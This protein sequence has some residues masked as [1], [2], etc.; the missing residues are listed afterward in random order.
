MAPLHTNSS[1]L[2][3]ILLFLVLLNGGVLY[4]VHYPTPDTLTVTFLDV[5]QGDAILIKAPTG[6]EVLVDGGRG[7]AVLNELPWAIGIFD[8]SL[9]MVIETHPDADHIGGLPEVFDRYRVEVFLQPG[10]VHDTNTVKL[11]EARADAEK[12]L[13]RHI[14]RR[15]ER[16]WL[17]GGAYADVLYPGEGIE[18]VKNTNEGSIVLRLVYGANSFMLTG[19]ATMEVESR[20]MGN[21]QLGTDVLK[22]GHHGSRTSTGEE[23]LAATT[24]SWVVIS[25]GEDNQYGHPH[26]EVIERIKKT[27]ATIVSTADEGSVTFVSDGVHLIKK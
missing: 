1:L 25:A 7:R 16:I 9:D 14:A 19:D 10:V 6:R 26:A 21:R 8:R 23:W 22:A 27:G 17:G 24:P 11:L 13:Q 4:A 15:G 2:F 20:L 5:G 3:L 18:H 12:G